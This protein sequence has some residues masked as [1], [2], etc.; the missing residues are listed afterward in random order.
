VQTELKTVLFQAGYVGTRGSHLPYGSYNLNAIPVAEAAAARGNFVAPYVPYPQ[1]PLGVTIDDWIGSSD[2]NA[3]QLKAE[4]RF[5]KGLAFVVNFTH[6]KFIDVGN[7]GY[8]DPVGDRTLDRGL[9]PY[10]NPNRFVAGYNYQLPIGPGKPW[11]SHGIV[12]NIIGGWEINGITTY[13]SGASLSPGLSVNNCV[14]GN[15]RSAPNV[16]GNPM[17]GPQSLTQWFNTS[18]FSLPAQYTV[19]DAGRGLITGPHLFS[20]DLNTGKRF[21]LPWREMSLEFRAEFYNAFNH[22]NFSN[23]DVNLGDANF[24]KVTAYSSLVSPRK[25]QLALK[26][27]FLNA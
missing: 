3:L 8:L 2:Y 9:S 18:V 19:G 15:S 6:S 16:S 12:G 10:N 1:Y 20:T 5:A 4:K 11:L 25:G 26:L 14:C 13:Q 23:P 17:T 22:P 27:Y 24:G 21:T 7:A